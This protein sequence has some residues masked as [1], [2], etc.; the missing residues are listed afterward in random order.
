MEEEIEEEEE[1]T[2]QKEKV[3]AAE[4]G[5]KIVNR[6]GVLELDGVYTVLGTVAEAF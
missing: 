4:G 1:K 3:I 5:M 2:E 6:G